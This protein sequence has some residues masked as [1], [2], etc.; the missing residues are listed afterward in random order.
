[1]DQIHQLEDSTMSYLQYTH[2]KYK[3]AERLKAK[4]EKLHQANNNKKLG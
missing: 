4:M 1:M 3:I 2:Q